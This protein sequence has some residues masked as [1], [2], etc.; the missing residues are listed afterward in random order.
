MNVTQI[1]QTLRLWFTVVG[2]CV[3]FLGE[4]YF[5]ADPTHWWLSGI[6]LAL[7][8]TGVGAAVICGL[9]AKSRGFL[10]EIPGWR[11]CLAWQSLVLLS[12]FFYFIYSAVMAG[13][14]QPGTFI[15]KSL[16]ASWVVLGI[17][18]IF[19]GLGTEWAHLKNG[20]GD[21]AEPRRVQL[22]AA[23]WLRVGILLVIL[24]SINYVAVKKNIAWDL[25]YLKTTSPSQST[26]QLIETLPRQVDVA[27]FFPGGN[28]VLSKAH[29]YFEELKTRGDKLSISVYDMEINP[30]EAESFKASRN[31]LIVLRS[32]GQTERIDL[33][34]SLE[35][36]RKG[37][38][39]LDGEFQKALVAISQKKKTLYF[40]R[41]H[42]ELS[43]V[44]DS[45]ESG[46]LQTIARLEEF[47][48]NSGYTL[49]FFGLSDGAASGVPA[50]ADAVV[51]VGG[52]HPFTLEEA[53]S[54]KNYVESGGRLF[55]LLD[56][57][58]PTQDVLSRGVR[59]ASKDPLIK[60]LKESGV[61][62]QAKVLA[63]ESNHARGTGTKADVWFLFSN[64]F[65]SHASVQT[66]AKN[67]QR[68]ALIFLK[69]GYFTSKDEHPSWAIS[70][71]V[72]SLS[73]TF[74][75]ENRDFSLNE[76]SETREP[77]VIGVA[78]E[79][80]VPKDSKNPAGRVVAFADATLVSDAL[81]GN[82]ANLVYF[83]DSLRW[84]WGEASVLGV[85]DSEDDVPIR[86]S[87]KED[88]AWFYGTIVFVP[89]FIL[90]AGRFATSRS[91]RR[92]GR[93]KTNSP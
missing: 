53:K 70:H 31:G 15:E 62:F 2:A 66:L 72:R 25:S 44:A 79:Q 4:R 38:K 76:P 36:A 88:V 9:N 75:D 47:L 26:F 32:D 16:L 87:N 89:A 83:V 49:R 43:W 21:L 85:A 27:L 54:I 39:N 42:G 50:D 77:R 59:D 3:T 61:E 6:G 10:R 33:G 84:L 81:I 82:Q 11:L 5:F 57:D 20:R 68:A 35:G 93:D 67:D 74:V 40:T 18:A 58:V 71:T 46:G 92:K 1:F 55:I 29:L 78:M 41:G 14:A 19:L 73:D 64:V 52:V 80:K 45:K 51:V 7:M 63:N 8:V 60:W 22:S 86:H 91:R 34:V 17:L 37:L 56:V 13:R 30:V 12:C 48:R 24:A 90:L 69:S 23:N 65:T 28:E